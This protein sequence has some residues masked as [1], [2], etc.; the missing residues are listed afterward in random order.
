[1][2][3]SN[4]TLNIHVVTLNSVITEPSVP[5]SFH[6]PEPDRHWPPRHHPSRVTLYAGLTD[7]SLV[8][9]CAANAITHLPKSK[10]MSTLFSTRRASL[11][12]GLALYI[13]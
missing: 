7:L 10:E 5:I 2:F 13:V 12:R 3:S 11:M 1:M 9:I 6:F 8:Y 4:L